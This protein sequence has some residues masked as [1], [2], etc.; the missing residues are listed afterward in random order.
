MSVAMKQPA[1]PSADK[2]WRIIDATMRRHGYGAS[3]L[4]ESLHSAPEC[5][6]YRDE[7]SLRYIARSL[8]VPLSKAYGAAT[9]YHYFTFKPPGKHTCVVC[10]GTACYIK[11]AAECLS[12][13][14]RAY[15]IKA[16]G[17]TRD[18]DLSILTARCVGS[19]SYA[20][21]AVIDGNIVGKV[22]PAD[23]LRQVGRFATQ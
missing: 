6:G 23:L 3:A 9:F 20:P 22:D 10:L 12:A 19:C 1:P 14:E 18:G 16:G 17:T 2:R 8:G 5:V 4:I 21:V 11:G 15:G 13:V 7:R